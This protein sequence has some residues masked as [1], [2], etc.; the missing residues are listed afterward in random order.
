MYIHVCAFT[1][2][3]CLT[4]MQF[5][6]CM[7]LQGPFLCYPQQQAL[8]VDLKFTDVLFCL[9]NMLLFHDDYH[10]CHRFGALYH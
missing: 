9:C 3:L 1:H 2:V 8:L 6:S 5:S 7:V 4:H 10:S